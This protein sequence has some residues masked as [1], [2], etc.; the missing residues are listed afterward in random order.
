MTLGTHAVG[1]KVVEAAF[2]ALGARS[3]ALRV[4]F[5]GREHAI[6]AEVDGKDAALTLA[7]IL[8]A[9][10][11]RA[12]KQLDQF[13]AT[14]QRFADERTRDSTPGNRRTRIAAEASW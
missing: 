1:A 13:A 9:R 5:Y 12:A 8:R 2:K 6:F 14:L 7:A 3:R 10:P 11:E 4:E